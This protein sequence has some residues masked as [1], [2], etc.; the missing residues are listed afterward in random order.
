MRLPRI[1]VRIICY[2]TQAAAVEGAS[3]ALL[4][5]SSRY[6]ASASCRLEGNCESAALLAA[7]VLG[8]GCGYFR[9]SLTLLAAG[10]CLVS[11]TC[12]SRRCRSCRC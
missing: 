5:M 2:L 9:A 11:Q 8:A 10:A 6:K 4:C 3:C 7:C 12:T 1:L